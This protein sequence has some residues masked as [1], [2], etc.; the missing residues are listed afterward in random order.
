MN[1]GV[2]LRMLGKS[3]IGEYVA[4]VVPRLRA[5]TPGWHWTGFGGRL[6]GFHAA[7]V[8]SPVYSPA[9]QLE[10]PV[11]IARHGIDLFFAPHY[12]APLA[13]PCPLVVTIHDL[14]HL[15]FPEH[16]PR[17]R[18]L[19]HGYARTQLGLVCRRARI[20]LCPSAHTRRDLK[21]M[22]GVPHAKIRVTPLAA[23]GTFAPA[24]ATG[25]AF[26][27]KHRLP[28]KVVLYVGNLKAHKN[29]AGLLRA[30]AALHDPHAVLVM[31]GRGSVR[32][33]AAL[34]HLVASLHLEHRVRWP[35]VVNR[36]DLRRWYAAATVF[37]FP[38][39]YEGFGLPPLEAM[40]SGTPVIA[41]R[42]ASLPEVCGKAAL[43]VPPGNRSAL[44]RALARVLGDAALR[45]RMTRAG[46]ARARTF[47]WD[48]TAALTVAALRHAAGARA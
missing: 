32:E 23:C 36:E 13:S 33:E 18:W 2:D 45:A 37:A 28:A 34:H 15:R 3:G 40:S 39:F 1:V 5:L 25:A 44:T 9:E 48:R 7:T 20:I 4:Q 38:S 11:A 43:L 19:S 12:N 21:R 26:R 22:L 41:A 31:A 17:P 10:L 42:A 30:F 8:H 35:G 16:L 14:I 24:P 27:R 46:L 47:S 6:P 29:P